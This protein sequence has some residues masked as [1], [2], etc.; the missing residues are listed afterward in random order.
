MLASLLTITALSQGPGIP[1]PCT[2]P[3]VFTADVMTTLYSKWNNICP[4][5]TCYSSFS[6]SL[7]FLS[8]ASSPYLIIILQARTCWNVAPSLTMPVT[9]VPSSKQLHNLLPS[10]DSTFSLRLHHKQ[11]HDEVSVFYLS[12][13]SNIRCLCYRFVYYKIRFILH[14]HAFTHASTHVP[15]H[16][17]VGGRAVRTIAP[18]TSYQK[19]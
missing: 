19:K 16:S 8:I 9:S 15:H 13:W 3:S 4:Q 2:Y 18:F 1:Q 7:I 11:M 5:T 17:G 6:S 10:D 14:T 12:P